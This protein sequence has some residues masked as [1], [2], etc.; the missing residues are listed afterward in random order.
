MLDAAEAGCRAALHREPENF[1][2]LCLLGLIKL[3]QRAAADACRCF[4]QAVAINPRS[5]DAL[6]N[7]AFLQL[8]LGRAQ[9]ALATCGRALALAPSHVATWVSR[10]NAVVRT[11]QLDD[12]LASFDEALRLDGG[13]IEALIA[14]GTLLASLR[15]DDEAVAT[16]A[17]IPVERDPRR[18]TAPSP[19]PSAAWPS[20]RSPWSPPCTSCSRF[21][22]GSVSVDQ[23]P[24]VVRPR[25]QGCAVCAG[26][27]RS[28][29]L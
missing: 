28:G 17:R 19:G 1:D 11:G 10:G 5:V 4:D 18:P 9:E 25:L 26:P 24:A 13:S 20:S 12:A 3:R 27:G 7:L 21:S 23:A 6:G 2:A 14:R 15:R 22:A 8:M 29:R 16:L